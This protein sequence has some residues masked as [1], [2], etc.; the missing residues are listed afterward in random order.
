METSLIQSPP[1]LTTSYMNNNNNNENP[2]PYIPIGY[3][4]LP[5]DTMIFEYYLPRKLLG[6]PVTFIKDIELY[7]DQSPG[8]LFGLLS[9]TDFYF[10]TKLKRKTKMNSRVLRGAGGG[11]WHGQNQVEH[12]SKIGNKLVKIGIKRSFTYQRSSMKE[13]WVMHEYCVDNTYVNYMMHGD[14]GVYTLN[15]AT[16]PNLNPDDIVFCHVSNKSRKDAQGKLKRGLPVL[17]NHQPCKKHKFANNNDIVDNNNNNFINNVS[18]LDSTQPVLINRPKNTSNEEKDEWI[19]IIEKETNTSIEL[20]DDDFTKTTL[21]EEICA[22]TA[23]CLMKAPQLVSS[24][25]HG[26]NCVN[27]ATLT[28]HNITSGMIPANDGP[29]N[30]SDEEDEDW[31]DIIE[32]L[33]R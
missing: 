11:T 29:K 16:L 24:M 10:F 32:K 2:I 9:D 4:F 31:D 3:R 30:A 6:F 13:S 15:G 14:N 27:S 1:L 7:G 5:T 33:R 26:D 8:D 17:Q 18:R 28:N 12:V 20:E 19:D 22:F 21:F 23:D 25:M